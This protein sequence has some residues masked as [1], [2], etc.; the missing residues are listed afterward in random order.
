MEYPDL[1]V[2]QEGE[3]QDGAKVVRVSPVSK[4]VAKSIM[5]RERRERQKKQLEAG[6]ITMND[7]MED[8]AKIREAK[9]ARANTGLRLVGVRKDESS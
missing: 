8:N 5:R 1:L 3:R 9:E 2:G 4:R 7:I 6:T